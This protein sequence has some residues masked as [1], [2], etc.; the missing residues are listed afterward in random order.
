[1]KHIGIGIAFAVLTFVS[2]LYAENFDQW[3]FIGNY[4]GAP[5]AEMSEHGLGSP[6]GIYAVSYSSETGRLGGDLRLAAEINS[7]NFF[8][9]S[10]DK[11]VLYACIA[12]NETASF[13][14]DAETGNLTLLNRVSGKEGALGYCHVAVSPDG[15]ILAASDYPA[16]L[17]DFF[18]INPDGSIG[19]QFARF[20]RFG[21]GPDKK[22]Q[23]S[24]FGH[25]AYFI[26]EGEGPVHAML[27]DLGSD[28]VSIV[29]FNRDTLEMTQNPDL[30]ELK[31]PAGHGC[32][33]LDWRRNSD[34][35]YDF[36]INNELMSS[37]TWHR[38]RFGD[39]KERKT[40]GELY[41]TWSTL[42][43]EFDGKVSWD[44]SAVEASDNLTL[45]SSTAETVLR[46]GR[47]GNPDTLYVSNRGHDSIAVFQIREDGKTKRLEVV[48]FQTTF[49]RAP[50]YFALDKTGD[51]LIVCNK[52][53]GSIRTFCVADDGTLTPA[54][55]PP[56]WNPWP[57]ALEF[58]DKK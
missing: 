9:L 32:R 25:S 52:R 48:Q 26:D 45:V 56:L 17:Y 42:P 54:L 44:Q 6:K 11:S 36:F 15:R 8:A 29:D 35:S 2:A 33:H 46:K 23:K 18:K 24:P 16:G 3:V 39:G 21:S 12:G 19:E 38:V 58:I 13:K 30:P 27:V 43:P 53:S 50:R 37:V 34:G 22:R 47:N 41:G 20:D 31:V 40:E 4:A 1:M 28:R 7:P 57:V 14:I 55:F 5:T 51:H 49:G 10:P